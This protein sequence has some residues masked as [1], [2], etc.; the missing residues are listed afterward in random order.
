MIFTILTFSS[1]CLP[2]CYP[3][4]SCFRSLGENTHLAS[5]HGHSSL[6]DYQVAI[7]FYFTPLLISCSEQSCFL[8]YC[9]SQSPSCNRSSSCLQISLHCFHIFFHFRFFSSF[10]LTPKFVVLSHTHAHTHIYKF[11]L[12]LFNPTSSK[13]LFMISFLPS[14]LSQLNLKHNLLPQFLWS[15]SYIPCSLIL[16][17]NAPSAWP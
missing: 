16:F 3:G 15:H 6:V 5:N 17:T 8:V 2:H 10:L 11:K 4:F 7:L 14:H 9:A 12:T 1:F 13:L